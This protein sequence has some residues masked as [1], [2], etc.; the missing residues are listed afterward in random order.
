MKE[1]CETRREQAGRRAGLMGLAGNLA[2][3]GLKAAAGALTGS[4][5]VAADAMNS[6]MDCASSLLTLLGFSFAGRGKDGLHP[7]GHGRLEYVCGF[8]VSLLI[9]LTGLSAGKDALWRL[10][11]PQPVSVTG[12]SAAALC[13]GV[14]LKALMAWCVRRMNRAVQSPALLAVQR[15]DLCDALVTAVTLGG[16]ALAPYTR[17][18]LDGLLGLAV[19]AVI[20]KSGAESFGE[21]FALLL[22]EGADARTKDEI[23]QIVRA[24]IPDGPVEEICLHDYGPENRLCYIRLAPPPAQEADRAAQALEGIRGK[25]RQKLKIDATLYWN[26]AQ[27][28]I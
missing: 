4:V 25:I 11:S 20:L 3:A 2:L 24:Y 7:Y 22:G 19:A 15:D 18:P 27:A 5:A 16:V 14:A 12:L 8:V 9:L 21:N 10:A 1:E 23:L 17:L 26:A 13:A 28:A 6:L